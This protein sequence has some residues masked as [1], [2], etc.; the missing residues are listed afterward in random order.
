M[1]HIDIARTLY[2]NQATLQNFTIAFAIDPARWVD[3]Q[4]FLHQTSVEGRIIGWAL[5]I[6]LKTSRVGYLQW[7]FL[8]IVVQWNLRI[9]I[10]TINTTQIYIRH[11]KADRI[12]IGQHTVIEG[13]SVSAIR[14]ILHDVAAID[15][16]RTHEIRDWFTR[17]IPH[18]RVQVDFHA[19]HTR[20]FY[21]LLTVEVL[22]E[23]N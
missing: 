22:V 9:R 3:Q 5:F 10:C 1:D 14:N 21:I 16:R 18:T 15:I 7:F 8:R 2:C 12:G 19:R 6:P 17:L 13:N 11:G 23:P 4:L 20:F